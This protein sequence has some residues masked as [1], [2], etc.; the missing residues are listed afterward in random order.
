KRKNPQNT[1]DSNQT[2]NDQEKVTDAAEVEISPVGLDSNTNTSGPV[3]HVDRVAQQN[4]KSKV[5]NKPKPDLNI[6]YNLSK[7]VIKK[8]EL[9]E[10]Q[11]L[12]LYYFSDEIYRL[13]RNDP[14]M[15]LVS[16]L[17][18][19]T[20]GKQTYIGKYENGVIAESKVL[21][22]D[23][24]TTEILNQFSLAL[25]ERR[26]RESNPLLFKIEDINNP[27]D[28]TILNNIRNLKNS[29]TVEV[30]TPPEQEPKVIKRSPKE[31]SKPLETKLSS[32]ELLSLEIKELQSLFMEYFG[33]SIQDQVTSDK[34]LKN[35]K[36]KIFVD[37]KTLK[38]GRLDGSR[39][40]N[41]KKLRVQNKMFNLL[42]TFQSALETK[43]QEDRNQFE[44]VIDY[45]QKN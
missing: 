5:K 8:L 42:S 15:D 34:D 4:N 27:L 43:S 21:I 3:T 2:D 9:N 6:D 17:A 29:Q 10:I 31:K 41:D 18:I 11:N 33:S 20:K 1:L 40:R 22:P 26:I 24:K 32:E 19:F 36:V 23:K 38:I 44:I 7:D 35:G 16:D 13:Y 25:K 28:T 37:G 39:V 45:S 12:F 30:E 14:T